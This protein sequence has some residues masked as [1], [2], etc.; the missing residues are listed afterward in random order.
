MMTCLFSTQHEGA[1]WSQRGGLPGGRLHPQQP[2][3]VD[4]GKPIVG[5]GPHNC[6]M[7]PPSIPGDDAGEGGAVVVGGVAGDAIWVWPE[8]T[9]EMTKI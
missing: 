5:R 8:I 2:V 7:V 1:P 4:L 3:H 9:A 6:H